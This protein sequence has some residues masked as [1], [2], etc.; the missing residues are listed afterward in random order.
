[1]NTSEHTD[2]S[3]TLTEGV[4]KFDELLTP[5]EKTVVKYA[6]QP[7]Q[8]QVQAQI[9]GMRLKTYK[10]H[11]TNIYRKLG[12]NDMPKNTKLIY[13]YYKFIRLYGELGDG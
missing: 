2:T 3:K 10:F 5:T 9:L 8:Q 11:L 12:I 7:Y 13:E 1:M 6:I 4:L